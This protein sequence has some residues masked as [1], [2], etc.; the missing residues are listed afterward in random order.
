[1]VVKK[2]TQSP[3]FLIVVA[4]H[5]DTIATVRCSYDPTYILPYGH[6][7]FLMQNKLNF[8]RYVVAI[9]HALDND[10]TNGKLLRYVRD[11]APFTKNLN[12]SYVREIS[13][14]EYHE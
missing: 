7:C 3:H 6:R 5:K 13:E 4:P 11:R 8:D 2:L 14:I 1:V 10:E 12:L 9:H